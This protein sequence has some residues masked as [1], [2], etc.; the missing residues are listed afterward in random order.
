MVT[1]VDI[2][3]RRLNAMCLK[4]T[5]ARWSSVC[6]H[7][8]TRPSRI[9]RQ[10]VACL[11][12]PEP[13]RCCVFLLTIFFQDVVIHVTCFNALTVLSSVLVSCFC[14]CSSFNV[15]VSIVAVSPRCSNLA[16]PLWMSTWTT[17]CHCRRCRTLRD[18]CSTWSLHLW[19]CCRRREPQVTQTG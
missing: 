3:W 12:F 6:C 16:Q 8:V 19:Y 14:S 15:H 17:F 9:V 1:L 5:R 4:P 2:V 7:N 11:T 18:V 10:R 13:K